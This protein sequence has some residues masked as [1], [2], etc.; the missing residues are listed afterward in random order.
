M[1][2]KV[3]VNKTTANQRYDINLTSYGIGS[4]TDVVILRENITQSLRLIYFSRIMQFY[5]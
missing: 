2:E 4:A 5:N 3:T 1:A